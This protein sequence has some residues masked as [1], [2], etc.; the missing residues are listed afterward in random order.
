MDPKWHLKELANF[1]I[2]FT[3]FKFSLIHSSLSFQFKF[4]EA[5][6]SGFK[7]INDLTVNSFYYTGRWYGSPIAKG[8]T[9]IYGLNYCDTFF[10][11]A[12]INIVL[13]FLAMAIIR[14]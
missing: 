7:L 3:K 10:L 4:F 1:F 2:P 6:D 14:H 8:Y 12:K 9:Y 11:M 13:L 5:I